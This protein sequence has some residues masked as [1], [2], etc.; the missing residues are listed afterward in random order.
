[1]RWKILAFSVAFFLSVIFLFHLYANNHLHPLTSNGTYGLIDLLVVFFWGN[2]P[3]T[4]D[5][6]SAAFNKSGIPVSPVWL[7]FFCYLSYTISYY[8]RDD[9]KSKGNNTTLRVG[10]KEIWW[11][12]KCIWCIATVVIYYGLLMLCI[13]L[14]VYG[15]GDMTTPFHPELM[16]LYNGCHISGGIEQSF[17][18]LLLTSVLLS[19]VQIWTSIYIKPIIC[20]FLSL[21]YLLSAS[22]FNHPILIYNYTMFC[23]TQGMGS[24]WH[25]VLFA[26]TVSIIFLIIIGCKSIKNKDFI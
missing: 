6:I 8:M 13:M 23:R 15:F 3:V 26:M 22:C 7:C 1:M 17:L 2:E 18:L 19:L 25:I 24:E 10:S 14:F 11:V 21:V 9:M 20:F 5:V 16:N 12:S 4:N